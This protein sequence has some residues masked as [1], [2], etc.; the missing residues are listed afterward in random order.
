MCKKEGETCEFNDIDDAQ[1]ENQGK[2]CGPL[3]CKLFKYGKNQIRRC[4]D[5]YSSNRSYNIIL[6]ILFF[7]IIF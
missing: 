7:K 2:C 4:V 3:V 1:S 5:D 6:I